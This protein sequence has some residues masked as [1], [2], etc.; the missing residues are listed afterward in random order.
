M[1]NI[2]YRLAFLATSCLT[3]LHQMDLVASM[4]V[5]LEKNKTDAI[6]LLASVSINV[7]GGDTALFSNNP[8]NT[9]IANRLTTV[10]ETLK[11]VVNTL[12]SVN[13]A[14]SSCKDALD[15]G[16]TKSGVY[17][18]NPRDGK[19]SFRVYCDMVTDGGGW[20]VFQRR[21]DGSMDFFRGWNDYQNG[22]GDL[23][24]EFWLGLNKIHRLAKVPRLLR[25][26]MTA[27]DGKAAH[28][29]YKTFRIGDKAQQYVID[30]GGYTGTAGDSLAFQNKH[31]FSTKDHGTKHNCTNLYKGA[32]WYSNCHYSNLNG[33]Y[34][35]GAHKSYADGVNWRTFKG[36][37]ESLKFTE[38][39]VRPY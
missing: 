25:V 1:I 30:V 17:T 14:P 34:H 2:I 38:M 24:G 22:F 9:D 16:V 36:Y 4:S 23:S 12:L 3:V 29:S 33:L 32:W 18:I 21:R 28:A 37:H 8:C 15:K 11:E 13:G 39:K 31:S 26:D 19:G 35:K 10:E 20:T 5:T 27:F 7:N 6:N